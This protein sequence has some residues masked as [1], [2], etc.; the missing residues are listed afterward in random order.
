M[1]HMH[2]PLMSRIFICMIFVIRIKQHQFDQVI[3]EMLLSTIE[4]DIFMYSPF[5]KAGDN[6]IT[7]CD[8]F[9]Q[10]ITRNVQELT[11]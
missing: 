4:Q 2:L 7:D 6:P 5:I 11:L 9:T 8:S 1:S 10:A 3:Q